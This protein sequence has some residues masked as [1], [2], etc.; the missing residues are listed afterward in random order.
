MFL[1][2]GCYLPIQEENLIP[3]IYKILIVRS[4]VLLQLFLIRI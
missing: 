3:V 1:L 4:Q 2:L